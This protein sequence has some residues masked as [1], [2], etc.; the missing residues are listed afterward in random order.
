MSVTI[1]NS[2]NYA[3]P[4]YDYFLIA[5]T[6]RLPQGSPC[7]KLLKG[8]KKNLHLVSRENVIEDWRKSETFSTILHFCQNLHIN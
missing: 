6:R 2:Y 7:D 5:A 3:P 4:T 8:K 1:N